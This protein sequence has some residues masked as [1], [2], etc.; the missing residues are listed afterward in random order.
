MKTSVKVLIAIAAIAVAGTA[1]KV[2]WAHRDGGGHG[3]WH[4]GGHG[5]GYHDS[6]RGGG[7]HR[8]GR[9]GRRHGMRHRARKMLERYDANNDN[10]LTQE[11]IDTNREAWLKE[12]DKNGDGKLSLDEFKQLWLKAR[13]RRAIRSF[14]RFDRDGDASV[15]LE[16]YKRPLA[17]IVERMDRN[18]DGALSREDR[19]RRGKRWHRRH[20]DMDE[21]GKDDDRSGNEGES[22]Q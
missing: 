6:Y 3:G 17:D 11:E 20:R 4:G 8:G 13:D 7:W 21:R 18:G 15:T 16:E 12:F 2:A 5:G 22:N 9:H 14:Q 1:A 10:K 19:P